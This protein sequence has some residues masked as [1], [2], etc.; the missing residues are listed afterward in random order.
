MLLGVLGTLAPTE[1]D[2]RIVSV[3]DG[4][5]DAS[6]VVDTDALS[7]GVREE[8]TLDDV[9]V[10]P[11]RD[12]EEHALKDGGR[13]VVGDADE[14]GD[15]DA[16]RDAHAVAVSDVCG[17]GEAPP[18]SVALKDRELHVVAEPARVAEAHCDGG[19]VA[20]AQPDADLDA[21][22]E[23]DTV[24]VSDPDTHDD[25]VKDTHAEPERALIDDDDDALA[26]ADAE[27]LLLAEPLED[28]VRDCDE[29]P[30]LLGE[31]DKL[32][33]ADTDGRED[34]VVEGLGDT[35]TE[36]ETDALVDCDNAA[37]PLAVL[38]TLTDC[39]IDA[40]ALKDVLN[41][42]VGDADEQADTEGVRDA[43]AVGE[44]DTAA[45][46]TP[47]TVAETLGVCEITG[48]RVLARL[49]ETL[50]DSVPDAVKQLEA[51]ILTTTVDETTTVGDL[52]VEA[53]AVKDVRAELDRS[54]LTDGDGDAL[55]RPD[56]DPLRH[57]DVLGD[58]DRDCDTLAV[59]LPVPLPV[60]PKDEDA[61]GERVVDGLEDS[62]VVTDTDALSEDVGEGLVLADACAV[63]DRDNDARELKEV[64]RD[65]VFDTDVRVD[66][67][68]ARD[69]HPEAEAEAGALGAVL[70][71]DV[72]Q[73]DAV[74]E[75]EAGG[76]AEDEDDEDDVTLSEKL[77]DGVLVVESDGVG[78][79]AALSV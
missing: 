1:R 2:R 55:G 25:A 45:L 78:E 12:A 24:P 64:L 6:A 3:D 5:G 13:D 19:T 59:L 71:E 57:A 18:E 35:S 7:D 76:E 67:V 27:P 68:A 75:T 44:N 53:D 74:E 79:A 54:S 9:C 66:G 37:L 28:G 40:H 39:D 17:L 4:L 60:A 42:A 34:D 11:D 47:L 46:G 14:Q 58:G 70:K 16:V 50:S 69:E 43:H 65:A 62:F 10:D 61:R 30:V 72:A 23:G 63:A 73:G 22:A 52:N 51:D 33:L 36:T 26:C 29:L 56:D 41:E 77:D 32:A 20:V 8:L 21:A 31:A 49:D 15:T 48:V 38:C